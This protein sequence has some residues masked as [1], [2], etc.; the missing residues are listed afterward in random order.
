MSA[1]Q[2]YLNLGDNRWLIARCGC[3]A[4]QR[5][6]QLELGQRASELVRELEE[7]FE[8]HAGVE[9]S[10]PLALPAE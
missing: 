8:Q 10:P 9:T 6:R 4:W 1:H 3:G 7:E 2:L 5:E